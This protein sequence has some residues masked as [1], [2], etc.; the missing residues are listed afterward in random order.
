MN[1]VSINQESSQTQ[2]LTLTP[3]LFHLGTNYTR[4]KLPPRESKCP[5]VSARRMPIVTI[6]LNS[7]KNYELMSNL[8]FFSFG[9]LITPTWG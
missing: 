9:H 2:E 7:N 6:N 5:K 8:V 1:S 4:K 3:S